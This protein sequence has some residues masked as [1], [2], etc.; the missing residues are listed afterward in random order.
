MEIGI[1]ENEY[2]NMMN[3]IIKKPFIEQYTLTLNKETEMNYFI[4]EIKEEGRDDLNLLFTL[5]SDNILN[6]IEI[7]LNNT[8]KAI[9]LY[10]YHFNIILNLF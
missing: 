5:N 4:E 2:L 8:L 1:F 3:N 9:R 7:K 6:D 10:N